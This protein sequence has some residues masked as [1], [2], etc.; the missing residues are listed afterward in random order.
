MKF[1][2]TMITSGKLTYSIEEADRAVM[3]VRHIQAHL[4]PSEV[5]MCKICNDNIHVIELKESL[6]ESNINRKL[7]ISF[8]IWLKLRS[9]RSYIKLGDL[10]TA[11]IDIENDM[12]YIRLHYMTEEESKLACDMIE[13]IK[14]LGE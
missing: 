4:K 9:T 13:K 6:V 11:I 5:V 2:D 8:D 7:S 14:K 1:D 12:E 3:F 10:N